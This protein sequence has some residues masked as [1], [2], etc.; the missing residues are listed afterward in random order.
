M[1]GE[2]CALGAGSREGVE[3]WKIVKLESG[4]RCRYAAR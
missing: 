4:S 3:K 1:E 2:S